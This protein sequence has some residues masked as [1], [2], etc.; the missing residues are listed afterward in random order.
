MGFANGGEPTAYQ[1]FGRLALT[2]F[3]EYPESTAYLDEDH[4]VNPTRRF[5]QAG[6]YQNFTFTVADSSKAISA[7]LVYSDAPGQVNASVPRVND[8]DMY[9]MQGGAVYC[10]GQYG[11]QYATR[12]SS[13]WLPDLDNN[14]KRARIAPNSFTGQFTIQVVAGAVSANAVPGRDNN[15][16]NQDWA[17]YV[18]NAIP[19]F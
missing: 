2:G 13:C 8:V 4:A 1:G 17:L 7:V 3:L 9:V 14:V 15:A 18:Y 16:A 5:L 11:G 19:N 12:S 6:S 10:D